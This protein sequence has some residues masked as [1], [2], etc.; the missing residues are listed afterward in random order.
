M[1]ITITGTNY[2]Q[3]TSMDTT[4][5]GGSW[6]GQTPVTDSATYKEG[7]GAISFVMKNGTEVTTFT[8]TSPI[9]LSGTKH[10]RFW[11]LATHGGDFSSFSLGITDG[12]NTGY[13]QLVTLAEYPGGWYQCIVDVS[14]AVDSGTKPTSMNAITDFI[15][16]GVF[17]GGKNFANFWLDNLTYCDGIQVYGDDTGGSFDF[18]DIYA[19]AGLLAEATGVIEFY[20]GV[21]YIIGELLFGDTATAELNFIALNFQVVFVDKSSYVN[22]ALYSITVQGNAT[23]AT[24][25]FELGEKSGTAGINGCSVI[26]TAA[27]L[28]YEFTAT[29]TDVDD[30]GLYGSTFNTHGTF[31]LQPDGAALEVLNCTFVNAQGQFQPNTMDVTN[32][33]FISGPSAGNGTV[34]MESA[35]HNITYCSF[36]SNPDAI[37]L[38]VAASVTFT[39]LIFVNNTWDVY[40]SSGSARTI[41]QTNSDASSYNPAGDAVSFETTVGIDIHIQD[42]DGNDIVGAQVYMQKDS[43]TTYNSHATNNSVG[44]ITF[45]ASAAVDSDT[46]AI[47][48][49]IVRAVDEKEWHWYRYASRTSTVFTLPTE[50]TGTA[51]NSGSE[52][53]TLYDVAIDFEAGDIIEGDILINE[54]DS[55]WCQIKSITDSDYIIHT[56]L[57]DGTNDHWSSG[58]NYSIHSLAQTYDGSDTFRVPLVNT[59]TDGTGDVSF[60]YVHPGGTVVA[61]IKVRHSPDAGTKYIPGSAS[62]S[63]TGAY[64][65]TIALFEDTTAT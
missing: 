41:S 2:S 34:L 55:S 42:T 9:D 25:K 37:E 15:F 40:N 63:F 64:S 23:G 14:S 30:F 3:I 24:Q 62:A 58:D 52:T 29:D 6:D 60:S 17:T 27:S 61:T 4:S 7:G 47:G 10:V 57:V 19:D 59:N 16:T 13:W 39:N 21:Y 22:A 50:I 8:P 1:V 28:A 56:P 38:S 44:D 45:E 18:A 35:T 65:T 26:C 33:N 46:A 49:L 12:G 11:M 5:T 32:C 31:D 54:T 48:W 43:P 53:T 51:D 36:I 20:N